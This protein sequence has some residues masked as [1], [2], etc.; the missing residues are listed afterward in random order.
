MKYPKKNQPFD[1]SL[2]N[3]NIIDD[4]YMSGRRQI[5]PELGYESDRVNSNKEQR[6]FDISHSMCRSNKV[7]GL[8]GASH[9][10]GISSRSS[11]ISKDE[12]SKA[13]SKRSVTSRSHIGIQIDESISKRGSGS[14]QE[15]EGEEGG[16]DEQSQQDSNMDEYGRQSADGRGRGMSNNGDSIKD[17]DE[18]SSG[19]ED[20]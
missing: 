8:H 2:P 5:N 4:D 7:S 14:D 15:E 19:D 16:E 17:P 20:S 9:S 6:D 11:R 1:G 18:V 3:V 10:I 12:R 13:G